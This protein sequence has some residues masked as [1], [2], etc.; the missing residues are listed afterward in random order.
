MVGFGFNLGGF[1]G[2]TIR[3]MSSKLISEFSKSD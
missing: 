2:I 3:A 1:S